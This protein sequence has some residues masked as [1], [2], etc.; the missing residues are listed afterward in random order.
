MPPIHLVDGCFYGEPDVMA[1]LLDWAKGKGLTKD[2]MATTFD[3]GCVMEFESLYL[4][5]NG[6]GIMESDDGDRTKYYRV[7]E[8]SWKDGLSHGFGILTDFVGSER[9]VGGWNEGFKHGRGTMLFSNGDRYEGEWARGEIEGRGTMLFSNGDRYEGEWE[10]Q[11]FHGMGTLH[12]SDGTFVE[13]EWALGLLL[14]RFQGETRQGLPHGRGVYEFFS[15]KRYEGEWEN[16]YEHGQGITEFPNGERFEGEWLEGLRHGKGKH[17][18]DDAHFHEYE[19]FHG[20]LLQIIE[21]SEDGSEHTVLEDRNEILEAIEK[22]RSTAKKL[23]GE[24]NQGPRG[25]Y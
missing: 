22:M 19:Y 21:F 6:H 2:T 18:Y 5:I 10:G 16:G 14:D 24:N 25:V 23:T 15:G 20:E 11:L 9:Y 1:D 17:Y 12:C 7:Y 4:P 8:G 13:G 3:G